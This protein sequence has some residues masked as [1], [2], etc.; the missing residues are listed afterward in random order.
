MTSSVIAVDATQ[1]FGKKWRQISRRAHPAKMRTSVF[2]SNGPV[3]LPEPPPNGK[4]GRRQLQAF[5]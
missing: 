1:E 4:A 3:S 2:V 5:V